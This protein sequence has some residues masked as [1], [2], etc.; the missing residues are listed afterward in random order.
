MLGSLGRCGPWQPRPGYQ[1]VSTVVFGIDLGLELS[2]ESDVLATLVD[3]AIF[4]P[5]R[6]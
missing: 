2:Q 5:G 3:G 6:S 1:S 4:T